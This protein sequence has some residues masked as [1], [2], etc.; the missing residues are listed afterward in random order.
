MNLHCPSYKYKINQKQQQQKM[1]E[2]E[3]K[4]HCSL[5]VSIRTIIALYVCNSNTEIGHD[6]QSQI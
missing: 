4:V 6:V 2:R 1:V 3:K 5:G